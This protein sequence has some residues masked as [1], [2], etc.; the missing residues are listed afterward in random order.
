[1]QDFHTKIHYQKPV[2][3]QIE[4]EIQSGPITKNGVLRVRT[5]CKELIRCTN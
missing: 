2:L 4:R 3:R 5:Y 1:M